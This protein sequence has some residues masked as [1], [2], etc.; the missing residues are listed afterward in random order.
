MVGRRSVSMGRFLIE[1]IVLSS[2]G[3]LAGLAGAKARVPVIFDS[4]P[5]LLVFASALAAGLTFDFVSARKAALM[6]PVEA[7]AHP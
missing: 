7:L 2:L 3:E 6:Q 4:W 5:T 1:A